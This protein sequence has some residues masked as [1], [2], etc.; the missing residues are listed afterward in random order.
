[1]KKSPVWDDAFNGL[2]MCASKNFVN[3]QIFFEM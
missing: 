3:I 1:M 2:I